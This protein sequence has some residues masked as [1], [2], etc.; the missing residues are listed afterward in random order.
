MRVL[1][2]VL[3]MLALPASANTAV[4]LD[5]WRSQRFQLFK[6]VQ[7]A[8]ARDRMSIAADDAA[9]IAYRVL[10]Q[11]L[12]GARTARWSWSVSQ[13]VPA[14]RLDRRGGDDRN[15]AL[16]FAFLP[17]SEAAS[18]GPNASVGRL[19]R[20]PQGRVLV[21]VYGGAHSRGDFLP[22]PYLDGRGVTI[23]RR[24]AGTGSHAEEVDLARDY[25][26]A[27]GGAPGA[28]VAMAISSD[29]DDTGSMVRAQ[30]SGLTLR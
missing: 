20:N 3:S 11:S 23:I 30:V 2:F 24:P 16:Y 21:Y 7:F 9:S 27:F 15:I 25:A 14:T 29:S 6:Q 8:G 10:P 17:A 1:V 22:S 13:S 12:H 5:D 18:V 19:M 28:L 26:R 4:S